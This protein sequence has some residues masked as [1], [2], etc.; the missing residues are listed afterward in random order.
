MYVA[1]SFYR[2]CQSSFANGMISHEVFEARWPRESTLEVRYER[3]TR[4]GAARAM[5]KN[6][7]R[8]GSTAWDIVP[9]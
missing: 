4:K 8:H 9:A 1:I 2:P 5:K 7:M 6:Y 3:A